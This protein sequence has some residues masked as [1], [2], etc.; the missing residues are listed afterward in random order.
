MGMGVSDGGLGWGGGMV[1]RQ[2]AA[3]HGVEVNHVGVVEEVPAE[4]MWQ[5]R[6]RVVVVENLGGGVG[7]EEL[8]AAFEV[9]GGGRL[10]NWSP[11]C[12]WFKNKKVSKIVCGGYHSLA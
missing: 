10:Q 7:E 4:A 1:T 8:R 6:D 3:V 11:M 12:P 9:G 2:V 5:A